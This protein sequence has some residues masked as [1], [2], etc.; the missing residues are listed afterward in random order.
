MMVTGS[1]AVG[2]AM[3]AGQTACF[4]FRVFVKAAALDKGAAGTT[5]C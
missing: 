3:Y 4:Y 2:F 1:Q 5:A